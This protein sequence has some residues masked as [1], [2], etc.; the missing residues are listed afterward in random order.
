VVKEF[1]FREVNLFYVLFLHERI[2]LDSYENIFMYNKPHR[3]LNDVHM[4]C[5]NFGLVGYRAQMVIIL[6]NTS[7][8]HPI[9]CTFIVSFVFDW[10]LL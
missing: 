10:V 8:L 5:K 1:L 6:N 4:L 2:I 7:C 3:K 9:M